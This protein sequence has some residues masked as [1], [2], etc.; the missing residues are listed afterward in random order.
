MR[1]GKPR[2]VQELPFEP[3]IVRNSVHPVAR[4]READRLEMDPDLVRPAG[5]EANAQ[6]GSLTQLPVDL[7]VRDR[8]SRRGRVD[9]VPR[10]L[11]AVPADRRLD[12]AAPRARVAAHER[13]VLA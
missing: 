1:E 7:E 11:M 12:P 10:R 3:E 5:L 2:G 4:N 8:L 6:D 9:R 13:Q